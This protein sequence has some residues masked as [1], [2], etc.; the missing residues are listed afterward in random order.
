MTPELL[1]EKARRCV[2]GSLLEE[3]SFDVSRLLNLSGEVSVAS[4]L[5]DL[6]A[7]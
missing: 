4:L 2:A 7:H 6:R 5:K 1:L 3:R